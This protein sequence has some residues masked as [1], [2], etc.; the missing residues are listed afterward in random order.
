MVH[1]KEEILRQLYREILPLQGY[2][3]VAGQARIDLGLGLI[4]AAF[5][6]E[7]FPTGAIHDF[8][9]NDEE[10]DAATSAFVAA[11]L[12]RLTA[13]GGL[14][15]W[16]GQPDTVLIPGLPLFGLEPH[17]I[18]F[19]RPPSAK[20]AL[21]VLEETLRCEKFIGV[22]AEIGDLTGIESRRLQLAV[23]KT[24]VTGF[25]I[26]RRRKTNNILCIA[27]WKITALPSRSQGQRPGKGFPCWNVEL[28]RVRNGT[29]C[30]W[31]VEWTG[32]ELII[33]DEQST[34]I[35]PGRLKTG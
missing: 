3:A 14:V 1:D 28:L 29:P 31:I 5:P 4:Q 17:R 13:S 30:A 18:F 20:A 27:R 10:Q 7:I 11:L 25:L 24:G 2:K 33:I 19:I 21:W 32:T 23:E 8:I 34:G 26:R 12:G 6:N 22:I 9:T 35:V 15:V 16:I